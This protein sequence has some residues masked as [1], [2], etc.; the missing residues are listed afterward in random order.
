VSIAQQAQQ[1]E[2]DRVGL[3]SNDPLH[4][5]SDALE[6]LPEC[7]GVGHV[8]LRGSVIAHGVWLSGLE[9]SV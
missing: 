6:R 2:P 3:A 5:R 8:R 7:L 9:D 1:R 4:I